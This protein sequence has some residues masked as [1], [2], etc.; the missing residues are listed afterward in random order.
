M[1][2]ARRPSPDAL[3]T[4]AVPAD[5]VDVLRRARI[6][7]DRLYLPEKMSRKLYTETNAV[8]ATLG[9][10]WNRGQGAHVFKG[11]PAEALAKVLD[12][13]AITHAKDLAFFRTPKALAAEVVRDAKVQKGQRVLEPSAGDGALVE[14]LLAVGAKVT[15]VEIDP[16][17]RDDLRAIACILDTPPDHATERLEQLGMLFQG[18]PVLANPG[19]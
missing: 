1:A 9:G 6:E 3:P 13:G 5:V 19:R 15:A 14:A 7:G 12:A 17:R 16:A 4:S 11:S 2:R 18:T 10:V 8:L